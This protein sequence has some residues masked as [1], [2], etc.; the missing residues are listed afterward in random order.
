MILK[1]VRKIFRIIFPKR[2]SE[3]QFFENKLKANHLITYFKNEDSRYN[4]EIDFKFNLTIRGCKH[5]DYR[6]F[7]QI[8]NYKEY[9]VVLKLLNL[10][11][12]FIKEKIIID[13][14][15]NIGCTS[16]FFLNNLNESKIFSI[17]PSI[18]NFEILEHNT[19]LSQN[20][21]IYN[22]A[23]SEKPNLRYKIERD[24]GDKT[25]WAVTTLE[26]AH[27]DIKGIT[28]SEIVQ[29]NNLEII[30]LLKID[31]EGAERFIF[32]EGN[33]FSFLNITQILA[34]EIHDE[35]TER[36]IVYEILRKHGFIIFESNET[37]I[38]L[39]QNIFKFSI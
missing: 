8:F 28:I 9:D 36:E 18:G 27:G 3:I 16:M 4:I 38:G 31:I 20:I 22:R 37:T 21:K 10:N 30:S 26:H 33:D 1:K 15:A 6:V 17:E 32:K 29:E 25:D 35:F 11:S 24:F 5:S 23:L 14:G 19:K 2:V 7:E 13:A 34:V 39:N 12:I